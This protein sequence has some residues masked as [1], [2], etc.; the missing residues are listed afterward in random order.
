[1]SH[2]GPNLPVIQK[3]QRN[4]KYGIF[5]LVWTDNVDK[6]RDSLTR[7]LSNSS[8]SKQLLILDNGAWDMMQ[9]GYVKHL[10]GF[11]TIISTLRNLLYKFPNTSVVWQQNPTLPETRFD[12]DLLK[13][14]FVRN[15]YMVMSLNYNMC[16]Q[17]EPIGIHCVPSFHMAHP[18]YSELPEQCGG[19]HILCPKN[20]YEME[21]FVGF[22]AS[23][24]LLQLVCSLQS[25]ETT[26]Y[27]T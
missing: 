8:C 24:Y 16:S 12:K 9:R 22:A 23:Q 7:Y 13:G 6:H 3:D 19:T 20:K 4:M 11:P 2:V 10:V 18:W 14:H 21:N 25:N 15:N 27:N 5:K 17:L 26:S 1:M